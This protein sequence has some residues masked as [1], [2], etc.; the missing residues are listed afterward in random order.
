[1]WHRNFSTPEL[2]QQIL[3]GSSRWLTDVFGK[4]IFL[5]GTFFSISSSFWIILSLMLLWALL[6]AQGGLEGRRKLSFFMT[7]LPYF[8]NRTDRWT[9]GIPSYCPEICSGG[10]YSCRCTVWQD[11]GGKSTPQ[12]E[13]SDFSLNR[14]FE[15]LPVI[16]N[17]DFLCFSILCHSS[18]GPGSLGWWIHTSQRAAVSVIPFNP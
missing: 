6:R 4:N 2:L 17:C 8:F 18:N 3:W 12:E 14:K 15:V 7:M 13:N 5:P 10:D 11:W 16:I 1:M 9:E